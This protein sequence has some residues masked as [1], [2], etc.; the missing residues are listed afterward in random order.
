MDKADNGRQRRVIAQ[1]QVVLARDVEGAANG[2]EGLGLLDGVNAQVSLQ[3]EIEVEHLDGIARLTRHDLENLVGDR[4]GDGRQTTDHGRSLDRGV[5]RRLWSIVCRLLRQIWPA[6]AHEADDRAECW[7]VAQLQ[8]VAARDVE[9]GTDRLEG[10]GLLDGVDAQVGLHVEIEV[11]HLHR[12]AGLGGHDGQHLVS[13]GI[14]RRRPT[15]DRR[16]N[17]HR[18]RFGGRRGDHGFRPENNRGRGGSGFHDW[19]GRD[20]RRR[21]VSVRRL[22]RLGRWDSSRRFGDGS[23]PVGGRCG[24]GQ[25]PAAGGRL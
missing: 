6:F 9:G 14:D 16:R 13:D 5:G 15:A 24:R 17:W 3:V 2:L 11:E 25:R 23:C 20:G 1:A 18:G 21:S 19:R 7:V 22:G 10:L 8:V 4:I 12:I